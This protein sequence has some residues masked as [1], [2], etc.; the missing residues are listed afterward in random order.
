[1]TFKMSPNP[2]SVHYF[3]NSEG[4]ERGSGQLT[5]AAP[6]RSHNTS[7]PIAACL[8]VLAA[9]LSSSLARIGNRPEIYQVAEPRHAAAFPALH[10]SVS[11]ASLTI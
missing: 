2:E 1:M 10:A 5:E 8:H 11:D 3:I 7:P 4:G 6:R 9:L